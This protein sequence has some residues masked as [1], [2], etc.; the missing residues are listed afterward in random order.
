[1][2]D[3]LNLAGLNDSGEVVVYWWAPGLNDWQ[4][5]NM[6]ESFE[7]PTFNGQL[8]AYVTPWGGLNIAGR[9]DDGDLV[10]YWWAPGMTEWEVA[11]I[12]DAASGPSIA[13]GTEVV[14]SSD[15]GI[16]IFGVDASNSLHMLRWTPADPTWRTS[17]VTSLVSGDPVAF[18]L[19]GASGG[20][21]MVMS[22]RS[23]MDSDTMVHYLF[24]VDNS[25]W[26]WQAA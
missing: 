22:M 20:S 9:T 21:L 5:I 18:P 2:W 3:G 26:F 8:D 13:T 6:T 10:T 17:D 1:G 15:G 19:G 4:T 16:N 24:D 23:T 14:V 11:N 25:T 7:G 12:S